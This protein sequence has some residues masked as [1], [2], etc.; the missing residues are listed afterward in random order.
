MRG[1]TYLL[2]TYH[3]VNCLPPF[4]LNKMLLHFVD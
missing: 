3:T 2:V 1:N 4:S